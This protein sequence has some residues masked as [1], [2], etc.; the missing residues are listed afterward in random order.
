MNTVEERIAAGRRLKSLF[1]SGG[2]VTLKKVMFLELG[3]FLPVYKPFYSEDMDLCTRAWMRGWQTLLEPR[4]KVVHDHVG[5]IKRHFHAKKIR[6]IRLRNRHY[7][8]WL[9]CSRRQ[10]LLSHAPW[11]ILR[12]FLRLLRLDVTFPAALIMSLAHVKSVTALR[13][14]MQRQQPFKPLEQ[15][16]KE[17]ESE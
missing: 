13:S 3:G 10:L 12:L 6:I 8:T 5:T 1:A 17:I 4:S 9:Y 2:S 11:T 7:Y 15:I 14:Q 16:L